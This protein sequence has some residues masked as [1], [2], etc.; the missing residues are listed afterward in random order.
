MTTLQAPKKS[1]LPASFAAPHWVVVILLEPL[2][3]T[4]E[5]L[6]RWI[7]MQRLGTGLALDGRRQGI[8]LD[9]IST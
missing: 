8:S 2:A 1:L 9:T 7:P 4:E 6:C 5:G 3:L